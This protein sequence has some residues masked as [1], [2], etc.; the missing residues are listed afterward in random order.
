MRSMIE[1]L[2][3]PETWVSFVTLAVLEIVLGIDN[4]IFISIVSGRLPVAQRARARQVGLAGAFLSRI[5]LLAALS[6]ILKLDRPW[7][8]VAGRAVTGKSV[9]LFAGGVFLVYKATKEI[10]H[11][12]EAANA[13]EAAPRAAM[14]FAGVIA[15]IMLLDAVFSIDSVITAVGMTDEIAIMIAAN[16][17]ALVVMLAVGGPIGQFVERHPSVKVLALAFLLMIGFVLLAEGFGFHIPK[18]YIYGAMGFS[19]FVELINLK[20]TRKPPGQIGS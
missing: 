7:F 4:I 13:D 18:G 20:S 15:Q 2:S 9:I 14:T 6:W 17:V 5:G 3:S 1:L 11:K 12:V 8:E 16:V 10:H 19:V